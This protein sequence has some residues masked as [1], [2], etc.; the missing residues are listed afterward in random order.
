MLTV[1]ALSCAGCS[2]VTAT[3]SSGAVPQHRR[4]S[5]AQ[6]PS[7]TLPDAPSP[8]AVSTPVM[9]GMGWR[10][11]QS[12]SDMSHDAADFGSP[13]P[14]LTQQRLSVS[15]PIPISPFSNAGAPFHAHV[16]MCW[17]KHAHLCPGMASSKFGMCPVDC[18]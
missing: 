12:S 16:N 13:G 1:D 5:L 9:C 17:C 14:P 2:S 10:R 18:A 3:C 15:S 8:S 7:L 6:L 4:L 11:N